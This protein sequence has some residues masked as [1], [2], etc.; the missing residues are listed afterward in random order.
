MNF[1]EI[2]LNFLYYCKRI[3]IWQKYYGFF[4]EFIWILFFECYCECWLFSDVNFEY[5][6]EYYP[7]ILLQVSCLN[8]KLK[9]M[10]GA[11]KYFPQKLLGHEIIR[12]IVIWATNVFW[13][14][15]KT[16]RLPSFILNVCSLTILQGSL[17]RNLTFNYSTIKKLKMV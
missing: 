14:I 16:L 10:G 15:C 5:Y 11:M 9:L 1:L 13:K 17:K 12:S 2:F 8:K 6:S 4:G 7:E 3:L